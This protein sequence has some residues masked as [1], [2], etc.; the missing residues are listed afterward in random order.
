MVKNEKNCQ[1]LDF[2]RESKGVQVL[3]LWRQTHVALERPGG[4]SRRF[5]KQKKHYKGWLVRRFGHCLMR[6]SPAEPS[7]RSFR[8]RS[9]LRKQSRSISWMS[10]V[11]QRCVSLWCLRQD[12]HRWRTKSST[13]VPTLFI[14]ANPCKNRPRP[15]LDFTSLDIR[16]TLRAFARVIWSYGQAPKRQAALIRDV[17]KALCVPSRGFTVKS[18][19]MEVHHCLRGAKLTHCTGKF[20]R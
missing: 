6:N 4:T 13:D 14:C 15:T 11:Q 19:E 3:V 12:G 10:R 18:K 1:Q 16:H 8:R 17:G 7:W 20:E 9:S 2:W 5:V